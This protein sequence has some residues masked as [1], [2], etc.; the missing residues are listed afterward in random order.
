MFKQSTGIEMNG[1]TEGRQSE[2][3]D[4]QTLSKPSERWSWEWKWVEMRFRPTDQP[5]IQLTCESSQHTDRQNNLSFNWV[6]WRAELKV[7]FGRM[8]REFRVK[9]AAQRQDVVSG[10]L[11]LLWHF[12]ESISL[13][14]R[15]ADWKGMKSCRTQGESVHPS[16]HLSAFAGLV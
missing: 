13:V 10:T 6:E 9:P 2:T 5:I 11:A 7:K 15:A 12:H 1:W 8:I 16:I 3:I 14:S 4:T